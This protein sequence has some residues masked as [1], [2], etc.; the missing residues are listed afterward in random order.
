MEF[1]IL[2]V[3]ILG[4]IIYTFSKNPTLL[5]ELEEISHEAI[6][7]LEKAQKKAHKN[8]P[9]YSESLLLVTNE[10]T[11][12]NSSLSW[13]KLQESGEIVS[14]ALTQDGKFMASGDNDGN[15]VLWDL[16]TGKKIKSLI[17]ENKSTINTIDITPDTR[18]IVFTDSDNLVKLWDTKSNEEVPFKTMGDQ[19]K[20]LTITRN[21]KYTIS[22]GSQHSYFETGNFVKI[23]DKYGNSEKIPGFKYYSRDITSIAITSDCEYIV[24]GDNNGNIRLFRIIYSSRKTNFKSGHT[25]ISPKFTD[26]PSIEDVKLIKSFQDYGKWITSLTID[27]NA[28]YI[29]SS[30]YNTIKVWDIKSGKLIDRFKENF[31][32]RVQAIRI[33]DDCNYVISA[34]LHKEVFKISEKN[35]TNLNNNA[36][37]KQ[38]INSIKADIYTTIDQI[39]IP[40]LPLVSLEKIQ[41]VNTPKNF[42]KKDIQDIQNPNF[43]KIRRYC[44]NLVKNNQADAMQTDL[45]N[46]GKM[47]KALVY[48][49]LEQFAEELQSS[50]IDIVDWGAGQGAC[51]MLAVDYI[52]EKQLDIHIGNI[53][54]IDSDATALSRAMAQV[55]VLAQENTQISSMTMDEAKSLQDFKLENRPLHIFAN[56]KIDMDL[57]KKAFEKGAYYMCLSHDNEN[58]VQRVHTKISSLINGSEIIT[59]RKAKVGRFEK[60]E[61]IFKSSE[62][63]FLDIAED[64]IP[65]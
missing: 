32:H 4:Y 51:S 28:K 43:E 48:N 22:A 13:V 61:I 10:I 47:Y 30:N 42:Y 5:N 7:D 36:N 25:H 18:Y 34:S 23:W 33:H 44:N 24:T 12:N 49:A 62:L 54:L 2:V 64:E 9:P 59:N 20:A 41:N 46:N 40:I 45:A 6:N 11:S 65:F 60:Y 57:P 31:I 53:I 27:S 17:A 52:R 50:N 1:L 19:V 37:S 58:F 35:T 39:A 26:L 63:S 3:F 21:G 38:S 56:D 16:H 29:V 14:M 15:L 8:I 55:A